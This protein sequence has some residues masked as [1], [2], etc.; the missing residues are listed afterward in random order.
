MIKLKIERSIELYKQALEII[1]GASQT[2]S[3]RAEAFVPGGFPI[4]LERG[5]GSHVWDLDG[6]EYIDYIMCLGPIT[7]GYGY[8]AIN[9]AIKNHLEYGTILSLPHRLEVEAAQAIIECVPCAEMV[10]FFKTGAEATAAA[11]RVARAYTGRE[12]IASYGYHGWLDVWAA[13]VSGRMGRGVPDVL[14]ELVIPF[15][16]NDFESEKSL[17]N[18]LKIHK[19]EI[20]CIV[21]N[22]IDYWEP[23]KEDYLK[24]VRDLAD[25]YDVILV[26]DEI[27]TGFRLALGGAQEYFGVVPDLACFAKG[28]SSGMPISALTGKKE[29][30][31]IMRDLQ[32]S[33]TYGGEILSLA[34]VVAA[35]KEYKEKKVQDYLWKQGSKLMEG[36]NKVAREVDIKADW[37]GFPPISMFRFLYENQ[38]TNTYMLSLFL[39]ECALRGILFRRGGPVY[40]SF[41]HTEEDIETT[42]KSSLEALQA[43]KETYEKK[44]I[45]SKIKNLNLSLIG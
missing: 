30:M 16:Y 26:F 1:P 38:E 36:L 35:I 39:H 3:K 12:K 43:V 33:S 10:R 23:P 5:K 45:Q 15:N 44:G 31:K 13:L 9:E 42:V 32:I 40:V 11:V 17:E 2:I 27:V 24:W 21:M 25:R 7:L 18:V 14:K 37:V 8:P 20:A 34:A 28:M 19:D 41:S 6:N 4:F 22:P 29:I